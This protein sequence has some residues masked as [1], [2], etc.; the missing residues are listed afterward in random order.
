[1]MEYLAKYDA[2]NG[3]TSLK[4][5]SIQTAIVAND[6]MNYYGCDS[7]RVKKNTL[8]AAIFHDCGKTSQFFQ[9]YLLSSDDKEPSPGHSSAG[10]V[11][12]NNIVELSS[13]EDEKIVRDIIEF[14]HKPYTKSTYLCDLYP[15]IDDIKNVAEYYRDIVS[16]IETI[17]G[18]NLGITFK[19]LNEDFEEDFD[20]ISINE[21]IS[22]THCVWEGN[23][24]KVQETISQTSNFVAAFV[25][26][27]F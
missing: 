8:I 4:E 23:N 11:L 17:T 26:T 16:E 21:N 14:H 2:Q 10:A 6:I 19:E 22:F 20:T 27:F 13:R 3:A 1:M 15:T 7:E 18:L 12:F 24:V 9:K 25:A 5:H